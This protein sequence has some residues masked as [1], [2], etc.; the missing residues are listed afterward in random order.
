[1]SAIM[2]C[3]NVTH[4]LEYI[5]CNKLEEYGSE[6]ESFGFLLQLLIENS[7]ILSS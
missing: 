6:P 4:A 2:R 7:D 1:M 3:E 5:K